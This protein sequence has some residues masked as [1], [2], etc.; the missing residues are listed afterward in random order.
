[1]P[2][3]EEFDEF[4][5]STRRDLVVQTFALTGDLT[6]SRNAVRDAFVAAR[7][8]W[9]KVG[10]QEDPL[11]WVR[12][13][14][15]SAAQRRR[16]ARPIHR[17]RHLDPDQQACVEAL[18]KL[19]D[20]QRRVLVLTHLS[21][22]A[23]PDVA[24]E[25]GVTRDRLTELFDAGTAAL[26]A[27]LEIDPDDVGA[28][29]AGLAPATD[30][31][32][33][34]R[35]SIVRR[36]GLR[37]RRNHAIFGSLL[38]ALVTVAAGSF[39]ATSQPA[40]PKPRPGALVSKKLLLTPAQVAP[41]AGGRTWALTGT[42]DNTEG[43]GINTMC[44]V[45]QFADRNGLGTWVRKYT[46]LGPSPRSLVQ[47]VEISSSPGAAKLAYD[48][49]LGWYAGCRIPRIQLLDAYDVTGIGE[50]ATILRMAVP[51]KQDRSFLV[52]IARTGALTTST[53]LETET[54]A[55]SPA[56]TI[57]GTLATSVENL[58][59]SRVAGTCLGTSRSVRSALPR[60]ASDAAGTLAIVDLPVI[61]AVRARQAWAGTSPADA[62]QNP[63]ATT[64]DRANFARSGA[65]K[66]VARSY[67]FPNAGLPSRFGLTET[68]ARFATP[69]AA[70]RFVAQV[71][72]RMKRC[73]DRELGSTVTQ[74]LVRT[75]K[76][77]GGTLALWRLGNQ[78]NPQQ[79]EVM[80]W[81]GITRS[82]S[83]VAQLLLT[84]VKEYDV[85]QKTFSRLMAR[86]QQ[87]LAE[88]G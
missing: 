74:Q 1:M 84:P 87:R 63:A 36:N 35:A 18:H 80:Y 51:A 62:T 31:V 6:A 2:S 32:K 71:T 69:K 88:L 17:E 44:Q 49:T 81:V 50:Q 9:E 82:G 55:P 38:L 78:V 37:R 83:A 86:A 7:H 27:A 4:Y 33:L 57:A 67:L 73:P 61:K 11:S 29:L 53:V 10:N 24:R 52:A 14:A 16:A 23:L 20:A 22:L 40:A 77:P 54:A 65:R 58:C 26:A 45:D 68:V 15:W 12:P 42:T 60:S 39:V 85:S 13:R 21:D 43:T 56:M 48:T 41:L 30:K 25:I 72:E 59:A 70:A 3:A 66:P 75:T 64:C 46:I 47:T 76:A 79:A 34:P 8:H 19:P 5:V 28:R